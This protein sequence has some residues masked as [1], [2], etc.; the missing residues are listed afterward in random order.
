MVLGQVLKPGAYPIQGEARLLDA[1]SQAGGPTTKADLRRVALSRLGAVRPQTLDLQPLLEQGETAKSELNV[2]LQPG[3]TLVLAETDQQVYV[4]GRVA[5]P[6]VYPIKPNGRVL[7]ALAMAGGA[8]VDG[9]LS[10]AVLVRRDEK[11]QPVAKRLDVK[12]MMAK[13]KMAENELLQPGD[14]LF[15]S[16]KKTRKPLQ[17]IVGLIWPLSGLFNV[18]RR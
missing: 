9:D 15:V 12:Q 13:G 17:D 3:D 10:R 1:L 8:A 7:D 14:V 4:L 6:D 2:L 5:K 11:G 16:D 18:L